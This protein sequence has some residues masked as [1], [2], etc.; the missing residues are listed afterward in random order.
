MRA[1]GSAGQTGT[2]SPV[3]DAANDLPGDFLR[4]V[5]PGSI[6]LGLVIAAVGV[7]A[8]FVATGPDRWRATSGW[9]LVGVSGLLL[10]TNGTDGL[11]LGLGSR[12]TTVCVLAA[13][14]L[15][16]TVPAREREEAHRE[17]ERTLDLA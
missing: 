10:L 4:N 7:A 14:G 8:W 1:A 3:F 15:S 2:G 5:F 9:S 11:V 13:L 12:A 16:L 6:G 17:P